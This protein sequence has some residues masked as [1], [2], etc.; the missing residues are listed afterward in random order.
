[1]SDEPNRRLVVLDPA[2]GGS[3]GHHHDLN[4]QLQLELSRAQWQVEV[5]ADQAAA[6]LALPW[7]RPHLHGCGY[8]DP[9]HWCDAAG[10]M[11]LAR[12]LAEQLEL[13][14]GQPMQP[15]A[16]WLM[17]TAL[18]FQLLGLAR[19]LYKQ[20][21]AKVLISLMFAPGET[22]GLAAVGDDAAIANSRQAL[23][24]LAE[25]CR[26]QGH[27]L[28]IGLP[29]RQQLELWAPLINAAGLP[30]AELHP[31]VVG[32]GGAPVPSPKGAPK[33][34]LHWGDRK[35]A[36]GWHHSL[37]AVD[38]LL[39]QGVPNELRGH[40]WLFHVNCHEPLPASERQLLERAERQLIGFQLLR[41]AVPHKQ[42]LMRLAGCSVALLPYCPEAYSERSSGMLWSYAS[43]RRAVGLPGAVGGIAGGWLE[44]EAKELGLIWLSA[45]DSKNNNW[46]E[47]LTR[48]LNQSSQ[49]L[50]SPPGKNREYTD[51]ILG[52]SFG[53]Y[54]SQVLRETPDPQKRS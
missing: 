49:G 11:H 14:I 36:K 44:R 1:M 50:Q 21:A 23:A 48:V 33:L 45:E 25:A 35:Q 19:M 54:I 13:C 27:Q 20:P 12:R 9:R 31:A 47:L 7:L 30:A 29:S 51:L 52:G 5:W 4:L 15:V 39:D 28:W 37:V 17:H 24:A 32:A 53:E 41:E 42:M 40:G 2:W 6:E 46:P 34:L 8:L 10:S 22:L 3:V 26:S 18:P 16:A 43:A 38:Q